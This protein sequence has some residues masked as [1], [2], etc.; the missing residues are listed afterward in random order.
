[1]YLDLQVNGYG[2]VDFNGDD[3]SVENLAVACQ[4]LRADGVRG[5]LA[6]IITDEIDTM[7][8]RLRRLVD[9]CEQSSEIAEMILGMHIEGPFLNEQP[10]YIG[11]HPATAAQ[12]A[13][14]DGMKKLLEATSGRTKI[15]TLAPE[16]DADYAVT[17]WLADQGIIVAAGHCNPSLEELKGSVAAG[18]SMFTHLGNGCPMEMHRHDNVIQRALTLADQIWLGFIADNVHV[19]F[20]ALRNYLRAAGTDRCFVV[21][22]AISAAGQGAGTYQL[23][24]R[25]VV[26]DDRLATWAADRSHLMGSAG[27]MPRSAQNLQV[28][29]GLSAAQVEQLTWKNPCRILEVDSSP[30]A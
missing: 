30:Q 26:V 13:N 22:D 29:L 1:M 17:R 25:T 28:E 24:D 18:L 7:C 16:R 20:V 19:P 3:L 21:T 14:L 4:R 12:P 6:T 8:A 11:A 10:G 2:G 5:I 23:G 27:T 15:V 9:G